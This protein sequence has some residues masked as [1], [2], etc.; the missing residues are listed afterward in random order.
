VDSPVR[1]EMGYA[2]WSR[3]ASRAEARHS[4]STRRPR[5]GLEEYLVGELFGICAATATTPVCEFD[6]SRAERADGARVRRIKEVVPMRVSG[7]CVRSPSQAR[8]GPA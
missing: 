5:V 3:D 2:P 7:P 8:P 4:P 6:G 1:G